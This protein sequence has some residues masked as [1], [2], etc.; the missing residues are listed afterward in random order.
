[1]QKINSWFKSHDFNKKIVRFIEITSNLFIFENV[2]K[3][4]VPG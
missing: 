1:M 4:G 2:T 3:N